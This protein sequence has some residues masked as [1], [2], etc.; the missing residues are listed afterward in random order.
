MNS[1]IIFIVVIIAVVLFLII[2]K[3]AIDPQPTPIDTIVNTGSTASS[4]AS[5]INGDMDTKDMTASTS[6]KQFSMTAYYDSKGKWF[7]LKQVSVK[8]GDHV[9]IKVTNT[10]GMHDFTLD[11]YAIK[12]ELPMNQEVTIDFVANKVGSFVYYCSKPGHRAGGQWGTL[13]VTE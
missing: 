6:Y 10:A 11:E 3:P 1:K 9:V 2:K 4:T 12:K 5:D 8:K 7:S 13:S